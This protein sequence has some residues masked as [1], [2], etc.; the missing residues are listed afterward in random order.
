MLS[1]MYS[2]EVPSQHQYFDPNS[3]SNPLPQMQQ[4]APT[5]WDASP[6]NM[7][8]DAVMQVPMQ[9]QMY[10]GYANS[11]HDPNLQSYPFPGEPNLNPTEEWMNQ[12]WDLEPGVFG[13]GLNFDQQQELMQALETD[14]MEDIQTMITG[15]LSAMTPKQL[16][17]PAF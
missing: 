15:T 16:Y 13:N 6:H 10:P 7:A 2:N 3:Y 5:N 8:Y 12:A 17:P 1:R 9:Q 11:S 4:W 14:G